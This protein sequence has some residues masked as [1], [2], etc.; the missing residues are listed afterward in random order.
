MILSAVVVNKQ[1]TALLPSRATGM[2]DSVI[3]FFLVCSIGFPLCLESLPQKCTVLLRCVTLLT[4][5]II[6]Y[7][8]QPLFPVRMQPV[9]R[10]RINLPPPNTA[11]SAKFDSR[12]PAS[13]C[14]ALGRYWA[15]SW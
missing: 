8:L 9:Q 11:R 12:V 4:I 6:L 15:L 2:L 14:L 3:N 1:N 7:E 13:L 10:D 5:M